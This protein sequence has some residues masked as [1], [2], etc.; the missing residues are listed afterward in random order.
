MCPHDFGTS[1]APD[2][3]LFAS[4]WEKTWRQPGR[5]SEQHDVPGRKPT[6]SRVRGCV[7]HRPLQCCSSVVDKVRAS[8]HANAYGLMGEP[9]DHAEVLVSIASML[10]LVEEPEP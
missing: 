5:P 9:L 1:R 6:K 3:R 10:P 2:N 7:A 8:L 4:A